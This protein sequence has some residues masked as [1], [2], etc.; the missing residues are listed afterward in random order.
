MGI[1]ICFFFLICLGGAVI[2][3]GQA[4]SMLWKKEIGGKEI[5]FGLL[6]SLILFGLVTLSYLLQKNIWVFGYIFRY[7]FFTI[8]LPSMIYPYLQRS[9]R[10]SVKY[11]STLLLISVSLTSILCIIFYK[12]FFNIFEL[13][14]I[15]THH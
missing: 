4:L 7:P 2:A 6:V 13:L 5:I 14:H 8:L 3:I 11:W 9:K 1:I 10:P 15:S 12:P